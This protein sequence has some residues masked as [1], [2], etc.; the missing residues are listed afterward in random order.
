[1][2]G[3]SGAAER[4]GEVYLPYLGHVG[5][6]TVL[7]EDGSLLAMAEVAGVPFELED[8]SS[9]N[10]RLRLLNTVFRNITDDNIALC[11]HLVRC[12][13]EDDVRRRSF[14]SRFAADLDATYH[15]RVLDGR[16]FQNS[17]F[18]SLIVSPRGALGPEPARQLARWRKRPSEVGG[19]LRQELEDVWQIVGSGLADFGVRRLGVYEQHGLA[20]SEI[21][22]ALRL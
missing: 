13:A 22:E 3:N 20:F 21:A 2:R 5:P 7:L 10:A 19:R 12:P 18:V 16:I 9:R 8:H 17:Y 6:Q 15:A 1:M 4:S 11:T 14:R